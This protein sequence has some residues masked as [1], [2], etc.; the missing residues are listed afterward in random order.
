M[1]Q[2]EAAY[3]KYNVINVEMTEKSFCCQPN[4]FAKNKSSWQRRYLLLLRKLSSGA[5]FNNKRGR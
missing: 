1:Q 4:T 2:N 5:N 3:K